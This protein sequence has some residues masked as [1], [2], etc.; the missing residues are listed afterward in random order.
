L[1]ETDDDDDDTEDVVGVTKE[2]VTATTVEDHE[3]DYSISD[4]DS[5][6]EKILRCLFFLRTLSMSFTILDQIIY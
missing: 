1:S 5:G 3:S 2:V 4:Q 6:A